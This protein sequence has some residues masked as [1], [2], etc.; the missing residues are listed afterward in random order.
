MIT[1]G[2]QDKS[3]QKEMRIPFFE[4]HC[5]RFAAALAKFAKK[6]R[7]CWA[8]VN[9]IVIS[10]PLLPKL[11]KKCGLPRGTPAGP[12]SDG[13]VLTLRRPLVSPISAGSDVPADRRQRMGESRCLKEAA[14]VFLIRTL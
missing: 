10:T 3:N 11:A 1:I 9:S 13:P 7:C 2:I 8:G 12:M 5:G 6:R 4:N 14:S